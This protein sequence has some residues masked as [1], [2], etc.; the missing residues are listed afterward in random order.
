MHT[1]KIAKAAHMH[2]VYVSPYPFLTLSWLVRTTKS[3][4][5]EKRLSRGV[6]IAS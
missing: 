3:S 1:C 5:Q 6:Q 2:F 4:K